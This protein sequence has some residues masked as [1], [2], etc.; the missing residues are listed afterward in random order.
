M[1]SHRGS[2]LLCDCEKIEKQVGRLPMSCTSVTVLLYE[3][4][5]RDLCAWVQPTA[6][7]KTFKCPLL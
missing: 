4:Q 7:Y 3:L 6:V 1:S 5:V 2:S